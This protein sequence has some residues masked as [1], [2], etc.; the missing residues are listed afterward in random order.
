MHLSIG[1]EVDAL[2]RISLSGFTG[3]NH[4]MAC[5]VDLKE[6]DLFLDDAIEAYF[7]NFFDLTFAKK[8]PLI[9]VVVLI[10]RL[11]GQARL[12]NVALYDSISFSILAS[13]FSFG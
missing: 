9:I 6:E 1:E 10:L 7:E 12:K 13:M 3:L 8:I 2:K 5:F 4:F 11:A